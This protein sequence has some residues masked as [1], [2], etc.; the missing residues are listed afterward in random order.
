MDFTLTPMERDA[1]E[2]SLI[3]AGWSVLLDLPI[4]LGLSLLLSR[5]RFAGRGVVEGAIHL[6][7]VLPPVVVGFV[8]LLLF[9]RHGAIG[10]WL[11]DALGVSLI[12]TTEGAIL[13]TMVM[14]LPLLVRQIRLGLEAIDP[15][16]EVAAQTLGA[17]K[18][19]RFWSISLPLMGPA[20]L[21]GAI[22][23]FVAGLG[24]FGAV[25]T[26]ASSI[27]GETRTIPLA[28]YAALQMP[29]GDLAASRLAVI[30]ILLGLSG[31][32]GAEWVARIARRRIAARA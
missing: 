25:I 15:G 22:L 24:E 14:T 32:L 2:L 17:G 10:H 27:P 9:G 8:L 19:D 16:L 6:P 12:F 5:S 11:Y 7:L 26:F 18:L 21:S 1:L 29:G 4:A 20:I 28:I 13:A 31:L 3:V 23:A 30:S